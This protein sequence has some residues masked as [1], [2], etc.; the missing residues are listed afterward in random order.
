MAQNSTK[1]TPQNGRREGSPVI[2]WKDGIENISRDR[3]I[4]EDELRNGDK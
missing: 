2:S 3:V 1:L 4:E